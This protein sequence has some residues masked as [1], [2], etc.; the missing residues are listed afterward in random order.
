MEEKGDLWYSDDDKSTFVINRRDV[1]LPGLH[2]IE[3]LLAAIAAVWGI[4]PPEDIAGVASTF[5]GV[6]H[7]IGRASW[8]VI[9]LI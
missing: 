6:E 7:Q 9:V 4:V 1:K 5:I 8:R 2:N 3:N